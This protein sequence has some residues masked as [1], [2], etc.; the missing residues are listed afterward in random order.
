MADLSIKKINEVYLHIECESSIAYELRDHFTFQVPGF[1]YTPQ[2]KAKKWDGK[3]RLFNITNRKIYCG[4]FDDVISFCLKRK[5]TYSV[6]SKEILPSTSFGLDSAENFAKKLLMTSP[7]IIVP[8][9]YQ[10]AAF[11]HAIVNKRGLL[12]S[13]TACHASGDK[14]FMSDGTWKNI[15][16]I[17]INDLVIGADGTPKRVLNTFSGID[18]LYDIQPKNNKEKITVTGNHILPIKFTDSKK[19]YGYS[20][21]NA[22][23]IRYISVEEYIEKSKYFKHCSVLF[24]NENEISYSVKTNNPC[25]LS[26]YFI[27]IYL[28]DGSSYRCQITTKDPE[29]LDAIVEETDRFE[30]SIKNSVT[31]QYNMIGATN[32]KNII[33]SEFEKLGLFFSGKNRISCENRFI[34]NVLLQESVDYRYQLLAGLIDSDGYLDGKTSY[35]YTS[36]SKRLID[37]IETL[38]ISLGMS[39]SR[40]TKFNKKYKTNYYSIRIGGKNIKNIPTRVHRKKLLVQTKK[41]FG[42]AKFDVIPRGIDNY[43]GITVEDSLYITNGGMI[44]HNSGKSLIIYMIIRFLLLQNHKGLIIVPTVSLVEQLYKDFESYGWKNA[45]Q[46]VHKIYQGAEKNSDLPLTISTWQSIY[47]EPKTFF[48]KFDFVIGDEC[49]L[50]T[51]KS[52]TNIMTSLVNAKYRIGTTG[53]LSGAKTHELTLK[54]LFGPVEQVTTTEKLMKDN[55]IADIN[56]KCLLIS[57]PKELCKVMKGSTYQ[58]EITFL[59]T[60]KYRNGII[61]NLALTQEGNTLILFNFVESHGQVLYEDIIKS[62]GENSKRQVFFVHGGVGAEDREKVREIVEKEKDAI[63]VASY[64]TFSTGINIRNLHNV[65]FASPSKSRIRNLQ[66]IGRSLRKSD[67]KS[68]ATLFDIAD[69]LVY[70][71]HEN[72]TMR[73][74]L[75]RV[76]LYSEEKFNFRIYKIEPKEPKT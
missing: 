61:R 45:S 46:N 49:H 56:I 25:K 41:N 70:Q 10:L 64:G 39:I 16:D 42:R 9:D 65:I 13:P 68:S 67:I 55:H 18:M 22:D 21:K 76:K 48:E 32:K 6:D 73:H 19:E 2:Y 60:N 58:E 75:E 34:P 51:A 31:C 8:R 30:M 43:Y 40:H 44:T 69:D 17:K 59:I 23:T 63:I 26:P 15:E 27:G 57:Y 29:I 20:K 28:G 1:Q 33:F 52:L 4:L 35:V 7:G 3:I 71:N 11:H 50:F 37:N 12:L 72:Y 66:S 5:Y 24:Y 47:N 62:L 36:K 38:C 14:V 53:T 54:G 74:F